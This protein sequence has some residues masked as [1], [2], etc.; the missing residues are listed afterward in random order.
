M[1]TTPGLLEGKY[2]SFIV[3]VAISKQLVD[4]KNYAAVMDYNNDGTI[5]PRAA[6]FTTHLRRTYLVTTK[7]RPGLKKL[8]ALL[9]FVPRSGKDKITIKNPRIVISDNYL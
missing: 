6:V 3:D 1:G 8:V 4:G 5:R 2:V 7:V 9:N